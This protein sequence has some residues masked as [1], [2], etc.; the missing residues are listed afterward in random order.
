MGGGR[1]DALSDYRKPPPSPQWGIKEG[2]RRRR[3]PEKG[4]K[5]RKGVRTAKV[6][7]SPGVPRQVRILQSCAAGVVQR[8][9]RHCP[10]VVGESG[11]Q[12]QSFL[13]PRTAPLSLSLSLCGQRRRRRLCGRSFDKRRRQRTQSHNPLLALWESVLDSRMGNARGV[14]VGGGLGGG[15]ANS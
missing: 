15:E 4:Q 11:R 8:S 14:W 2:R 7:Y 13:F 5:G 3:R 9:S 10:S 12:T 1:G 6:S